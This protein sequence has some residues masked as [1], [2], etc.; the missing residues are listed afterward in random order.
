MNK[1]RTKMLLGAFLI[2]LAATSAHA[3]ALQTAA[4]GWSSWEVATVAGAPAWCCFDYTGGKARAKACEL[5]RDR[6]SYGGSGENDASGSARIYALHR[7]G[8]LHKLR[9]LDSSCP[10]STTTP[11]HDLGRIAADT[12]VAWLSARMTPRSALSDEL[13]AAMALHDGDLAGAKLRQYALPPTATDTREQAL[14]WLGQVRG[15]AS[16]GFLAEQ[17]RVAV[18][19]EI[20]RHAG[21]ALSQSDAPNRSAALI[22]QGR[23]DAD[24][25]VR[26]QAWFWLAQTGDPQA[27]AAITAALA[28]EGSEDVREQQIFA[29]SQLPEERA[30]QALIAVVGD[31][32][33]SHSLRKRA[34]FWLG[35]SDSE[36]AHRYLDSL[37]A[38]G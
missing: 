9:A 24:P 27:E 19:P 17:M 31:R 5:D 25:E 15:A 32:A 8:K 2:V 3:E 4:D 20:R 37:L 18:E 22:A 11:A 26:G 1:L 14:F 21:F 16:A 23:D 36:L 35:Q 10:V 38:E 7:G 33:M 30:V 6:Y 12:S 28:E 34:L 29:L 13:L